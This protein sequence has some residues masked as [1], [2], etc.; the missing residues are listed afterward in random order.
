MITFD[1]KF[2]VGSE[3]SPI[4]CNLGDFVVIDIFCRLYGNGTK[5][6]VYYCA[7]KGETERFWFF[8]EDE[9]SPVSRP[10]HQV[11]IVVTQKTLFD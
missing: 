6:I 7:P 10:A 11:N 8:Q 9:L 5:N 1:N 3:V 4:G 2:N